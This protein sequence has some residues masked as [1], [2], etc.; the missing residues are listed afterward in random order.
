M[1]VVVK[2][3]ASEAF[4]PNEL[5]AA[6]EEFTRSEPQYSSADTGLRAAAYRFGTRVLFAYEEPETGLVV[7]LRP[8][9]YSTLQGK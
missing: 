9:S 2:P 3:S 7:L 8:T 5:T 4:T 6:Y 1:S